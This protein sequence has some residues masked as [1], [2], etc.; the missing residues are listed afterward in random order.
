M[1]RYRLF[2]I[3]HLTRSLHDVISSLPTDGNRNPTA[4]PEWLRPVAPFRV[5]CLEPID[6]R[7]KIAIGK[8]RILLEFEVHPLNQLCLRHK[9]SV[10]TEPPGR[11]TRCWQSK[12]LLA[13][14]DCSRTTHPWQSSTSTSH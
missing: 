1:D 4:T 7:I 14:D 3:E 10:H 6:R 9:F 2:Q 12:C 8:I 5:V 11:P 13:R